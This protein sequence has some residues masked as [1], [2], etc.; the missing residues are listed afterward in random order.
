M[1]VETLLNSSFLQVFLWERFKGVEVSPL[2]YSKAKQSVDSDDGSYVPKR[3][4]LICRW[5]RRMQR[6][7]QNFLELLDN[8]ESFIFR[9]YC[10]LSEGFKHIPFYADSDDLIEVP[11]TTARAHRV[12]RQLGFDQGVPSDPSH[13]DPFSLHKVLWTGDNIPEDGGLF[14]LALADK[15]RTGGLSKAYRNY[16]NRYFASFS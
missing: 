4:P 5:S 11:A 7:G 9:P 2:P 8:V 6:K 3:L 10:A 15:R 12:R 14:A 16:W 13:G 1:A